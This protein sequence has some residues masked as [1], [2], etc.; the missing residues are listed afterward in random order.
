MWQQWMRRPQ[1]VWLRRA[2]FQIHLWTGI[3]VGLYVVAISITGSAIVFRNELYTWA[4]KRPPVTVAPEKLGKQEFRS[5][6]AGAYPGSSIANVWE[7]KEP[8][9]PTEVWMD[10]DGSR[11]QRLFDPYTGRDM[12][13]SVAYTIRIVSWCG[14]LHANLFG[15]S[16]GRKINGI[17][18]GFLT[19][20]C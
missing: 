6:V 18:A 15:G 8:K 5:K 9:Q 17:G 7:S 14:D 16:T 11:V 13:R 20:M 19:L 4:S 12:G 2:I 1:N 3:G 10:K